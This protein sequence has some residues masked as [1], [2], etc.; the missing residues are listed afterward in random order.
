MNMRKILLVCLAAFGLSIAAS[1]QPRA[2]GVR[3]GVT[4]IEMSY[5]HT[6][7]Q[8][9]FIEAE[10]GSEFG[11]LSG[12]KATGT[13]NFIFARPAWTE[14]GYWGI[15]TGPGVSL[16]CLDNEF[17]IAFCA[18]AGIEYTFWFPLQLTLDIRPSYGAL[19]GEFH[20]HGKWGFFPAVAARYRF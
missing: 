2:L 14:R 17:L 4:G 9:S 7:Q 20:S 12:F 19:G 10:L 6:M 13:Y 11:G 3:T 18:N 5:Q 16:G 8:R 1:A 15:Y